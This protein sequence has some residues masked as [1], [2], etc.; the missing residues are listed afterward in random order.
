MYIDLEIEE[1]FSPNASAVIHAG[2]CRDLLKDIPDESVQLIVTS[3]PYNIGKSYESRKKLDKYL[4]E[5]GEVIAECVRVLSPAGS[6]CWQVGNYVNSGRII[7][8]DIAFYPIFERHDL[9]MRN[10]IVWHF[11][12]GLHCKNRLS[13]RHETIMWMTK[14]DD[15]YF[16]LDPIRVPQKYPGKRHFKGP[17]AGKLSGNPLGKNPGD[18]WVF[19]NVKSNHIEKTGHPCQF[20]VE[21]VER[22]ILSLS[23]PGD[24]VLDP[25]LG[26]GTT[27]AAAV[28]HSR[29]GAGAELVNDYIDIA[30][31]RV[32]AAAMGELPRRPMG[33]PVFD[34]KNAGSKLTTVQ[35]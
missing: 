22:L 31:D 1:K 21:L 15:Y 19:P 25:Y 9:C 8:L 12:H 29:R 28:L 16:D 2:D 32:A 7:P 5:Q 10:R 6:L 26:V 17:K 4:D 11:E 13:G 20:P 3:P 24:L 23:Q 34:P 14:S 30:R 27:V 18:V 35:W 33:T